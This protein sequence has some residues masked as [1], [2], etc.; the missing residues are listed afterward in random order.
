MK[1]KNQRPR[2][3]IVGRANVGKSTLFNRLSENVKTITYDQEGVTRDF[4]TDTITWQGHTFDIVDT[5][6]VSLKKNNDPLMEETRQRALA[7]LNQAD[8]IIFVCD[9]TVG[10]VAEDSLIAKEIHKTGKPVIVAVNK[11]DTQAA[12][13]RIYEFNRFGFSHIIPVSAQHGQGIADLLTY[14]VENVP[15]HTIQE[16]QADPVCRVVILGKPNVGKSSLLNLL[17]KEERAIVANIPG[18]TRE[19][20]SE[21]ITFYQEDILVTDTPGLRRQRSVTE[22]LEEMMVKSS[23]RALDEAEVVL[24]MVDASQGPISDQELKLA[25]YAFTQKYKGLLILF[26]KQDLLTDEYTKFL[27]DKSTDQY[28]F[29]LKHVPTLSISCMTGKNVG[30]VLAAAKELCDRYMQRF[31]A[32]ELTL[33]IQEALRR[34]PLY[35][36]QERLQVYHIQQVSTGPITIALRVNKTEWFGASQLKYLENALREHYDLKGVPVRFIIRKERIH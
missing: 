7:Q 14:I 17:L 9:G 5:G 29:F 18:T 20:I 31:S 35:R 30:K 4:I 15:S 33:V 25:F 10:I 1:N 13:D 26:N 11:Q 32:H 8:V 23:L 3:V 36:N 19:A 28:E 12:Q 21:K 22:T 16:T 34:R 24:L 27:L 6:G 2:V